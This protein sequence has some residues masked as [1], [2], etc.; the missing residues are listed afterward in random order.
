MIFMKTNDTKTKIYR[1][2]YE[3]SKLIEQALDTAQ[4]E[5]SVADPL[6]EAL[7]H[8]DFLR[9]FLVSVKVS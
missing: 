3:V 8:V 2:L 1:H 5:A 9:S 4:G 6:Y 7:A